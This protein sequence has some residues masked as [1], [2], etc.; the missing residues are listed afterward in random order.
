MRRPKLC[1]LRISARP[2]CIGVTSRLTCR[3]RRP[4]RAKLCLV[5]RSGTRGWRVDLN[6]DPRLPLL[7]RTDNLGEREIGLT[8]DATAAIKRLDEGAMRRREMRLACQCESQLALDATQVEFASGVG[9]Q[10]LSELAHLPEN[11][12]TM[13]DTLS[14]H[15]PLSACFMSALQAPSGSF[16]V[17]WCAMSAPDSSRY[18]P[19]LHNRYRS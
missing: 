17:R 18:N 13:T 12:T 3:R 9:V 2:G 11:C 8:L 10:C 4:R 7:K 1:L 14:L 6:V 19:S 16:P 5:I 15:L